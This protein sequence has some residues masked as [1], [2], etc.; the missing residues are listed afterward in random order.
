[1]I[2]NFPNVQIN[3]R[4]ECCGVVSFSPNE[5]KQNLDYN[6]IDFTEDKK[7]FEICFNGQ[8]IAS[9]RLFS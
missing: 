6:L 1:M 2:I 9:L 4:N 3:N 8:N 7:L 5:E